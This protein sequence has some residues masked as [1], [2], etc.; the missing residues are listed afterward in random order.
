MDV[1]AFEFEMG[2]F[3]AVLEEAKQS[4]DLMPRPFRRK[5]SI[6]ARSREG[7]SGFHDVAYIE[8]TP[9]F[10]KT[11]QTHAGGG[12]TDFSVYYSQGL[13]ESIAAELKGQERRWCARQATSSKSAK[14]NK[15]SSLAGCSR[16]SGP[17]GWTTGRSI[18]HYENRKSSKS[19]VAPASAEY[20]SFLP[21]QEPAQRDLPELT[22]TDLRRWTGAF[23]F[24]NAGRASA[25]SPESRP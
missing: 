23:I 7:Q 16:R 12:L 11:R 4:I 1:L 25:H 3:P 5:C 21:G 6:S 20:R 9:R 22:T 10:D 24:E 15:A 14:T 17:T 2:L 13:V 19:S 18:W 8:V